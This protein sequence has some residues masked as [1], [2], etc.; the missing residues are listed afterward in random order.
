MSILI[1][2]IF[3]LANDIISLKSIMFKKTVIK[4]T[5][6]WGNVYVKKNLRL[7][8]DISSGLLQGTKKCQ[9]TTKT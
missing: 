9:V 3:N 2:Q 6:L 4:T 7:K 8:A 5:S 1:K